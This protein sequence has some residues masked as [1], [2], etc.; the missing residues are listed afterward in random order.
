MAN[1]AVENEIVL[2]PESRSISL[3]H[4]KPATLSFPKGGATRGSV[5]NSLSPSRSAPV[6]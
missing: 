3:L 4:A 5:R 2:I 6:P 1:V